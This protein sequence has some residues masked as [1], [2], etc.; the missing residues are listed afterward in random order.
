MIR[1]CIVRGSGT[2]LVQLPVD[3][4]LRL[5]QYAG[6]RTSVA[7]SAPTLRPGQLQIKVLAT[8]M[9]AG[10]VQCLQAIPRTA[11]ARGQLG[12]SN[13]LNYRPWDICW[14]VGRKIFQSIGS[15]L[16]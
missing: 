15:T 6:T 12:A 16:I 3:A 2:R 9:H 14:S 11:S 5:P 10:Q 8:R 13:A 1:S 7:N 4:L